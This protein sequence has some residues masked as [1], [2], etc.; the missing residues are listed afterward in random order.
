[1]EINKTDMGISISVTLWFL[2]L[3]DIYC[4]PK[5]PEKLRQFKLINFCNVKKTSPFKNQRC[6]NMKKWHTAIIS[7]RSNQKR[8]LKFNGRFLPSIRRSTISH[9]RWAHSLCIKSR[10]NLAHNT[11][12]CTDVHISGDSLNGARSCSLT[13]FS[14]PQTQVSYL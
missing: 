13:D 11:K 12:I 4:G 1:M 8:D 6:K 2:I 14:Q 9:V 10:I 5:W 7:N 3:E